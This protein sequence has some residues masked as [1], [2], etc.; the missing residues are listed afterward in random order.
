MPETWRGLSDETDW[1]AWSRDAVAAMQARNDGWTAR[2]GL[3]R[4]PYRWDIDT[5]ELSFERPGGRV[6]ADLCLVGTVSDA[7][8]TW[9]WA[10][11]NDAI[12]AVAKHG[13]ELVRDFGVTHDLPLLTTAE[14]PGGRAEGLEMAAVAGRIQ[15]ASG[16]FVDRSGDLLVFF[17]LHRFRMSE[18]NAPS[19]GAP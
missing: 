2:F 10:W 6:V 12:P 9:L 8:G 17:T 11:A 19:P 18:P 1:S 14:W 4:A 16:I 5:A 3:A 15:E 13:L 7:T